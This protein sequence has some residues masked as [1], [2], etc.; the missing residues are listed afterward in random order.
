MIA[1]LVVVGL[2]LTISLY[3]AATKVKKI[4][5]KGNKVSLN[6]AGI[7]DEGKVVKLNLNL[8][9]RTDNEISLAEVDI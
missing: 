6:G 7:H 4:S 2:L 9:Y 3:Y 1:S 8:P 5:K